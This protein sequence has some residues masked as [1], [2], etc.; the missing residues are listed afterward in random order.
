MSIETVGDDRTPVRRRGP[1]AGVRVTDFCWMGVG[2]VATR[3][4]ADFGAEVIRIEDR[5]R[6]DLP[7]RLPIYKGDVRAY[8]DEDPNP[9]PNKGG[10]FNNYNRN[11][12]G[13]TLNMRSDEGRE[14]ADRL[15]ADSGIVTENFA[16]GVMER[17][18]ITWDHVTGLRPDAIFARMSGYGHDGPHHGFRSYGPVIQAVCGLSFNSGLPGREPSGWGMSYMDNQAAYY[19]AI[20]LLMAIYR[21]NATG[22]G[23][24]IDV[25]A[26][27]AGIGLLGPDLLDTLVNQRPSRRDDFP[28]GN[29]LEFPDAAP[30]GVYPAAGD[31]QWVAIAVTED[32]EW[33]SLVTAMGHPAWASED[34][35]ASMADRVAHADEL[36]ALVGAWTSEHDKHALMREL[37]AA[38]VP[39]GAVQNARDLVEVDPQVAARG[40]F[41]ELDH[42]VIGPALFEGNPMTFSRTEQHTWRSAPLLGEDNT[43]V[44]RDILGMDEDEI[45][46]LAAE[47][48]I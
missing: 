9:D 46:R 10:L 28:R 6:P 27:E 8:G 18:G 11:K 20:A 40:T 16:P 26:V 47:E 48:I 44:L 25:S 12:V 38:G 39:A 41:F 43:Y 34:R 21:R 37:Q 42:P 30:H 22:Q 2:A 33:K 14:I 35:F 23:M 32:T 7:R 17:W 3:M 31:D 19:N 15:I 13:I 45:A 4:L 5:K 36:D 24:E 29:R 1:L